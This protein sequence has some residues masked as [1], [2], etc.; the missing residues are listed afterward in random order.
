MLQAAIIRNIEIIGEAVK[1][2]DRNQRKIFRSR[3]EK[4]CRFEGYPDT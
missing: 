4:D 2:P 1:N 3:M